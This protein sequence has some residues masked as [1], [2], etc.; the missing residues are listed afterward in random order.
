MGCW[1]MG[2]QG[3]KWGCGAVSGAGGQ[4][5]GPGAV[6]GAGGQSVGPGGSQWGW[7]RSMVG[8]SASPW[9]SGTSF[10]SE[11]TWAPTRDTAGVEVAE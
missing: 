2:P 9:F 6:S 7:G 4:S 8:R 5:V 1:L 3:G 10:V 11:V